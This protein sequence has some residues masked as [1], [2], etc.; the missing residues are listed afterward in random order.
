[1]A[2]VN[3]TINGRV[4]EIACDDS[5]VGRVNDLG[6]E[7]DTRA[8]SLLKQ[9]GNVPDAR[10]L[11]MVSLMLA[12]ELAESREQLKA[13]SG[14][15]AAAAD[16]DVRLAEGIEALAARIEGIADRLERA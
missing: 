5:Q 9:I 10:L 11:V 4:Y 6:R 14:A 7:V 3:L 8:Q 13:A 15:V 2:V 16:G 12:D 1:M